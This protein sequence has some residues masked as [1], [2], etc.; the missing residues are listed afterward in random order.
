MPAYGWRN[1]WGGG[2]VC[3]WLKRRFG[4]MFFGRAGDEFNQGFSR[5]FIRF[6]NF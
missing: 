2:T 1:I 4:V 6:R 3:G 5:L